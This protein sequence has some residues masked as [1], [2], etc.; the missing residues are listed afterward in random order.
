MTKRNLIIIIVLLAIIDIVAACWYVSQRIEQSGKSQDLF[1]KRDSTQVVVADTVTVTSV[2]DQFYGV[3]E[4]NAYFVSTSPADRSNQMSYYTS[5]KR[6]ATKWPRSVNGQDS[7]PALEKQLIKQAFGNGEP[8]V[9]KAREAY[10]ASPTFNKPVGSQYRRASEAP[11]TY[12]TYGNVTQVLVYPLITSDR[13]LVMEV[14]KV[15]YSGYGTM[16]ASSF[17]HYDR[18]RQHVLQRL[19]ILNADRSG[20]LLSLINDRIDEL[21]ARRGT[22]K[23]LSRALNVPV[24]FCCTRD[25]I[26]F[27]F[28]SGTIARDEAM[29]VSVPYDKLQPYLT[30]NFKQLIADND[31]YSQ[32]S[33]LEPKSISARSSK[34][35]AVTPTPP[36]VQNINPGTQVAPATGKQQGVKKQQPTQYRKRGYRRGYRRGYNRSGYNGQYRRG[37]RSSGTQSGQKSGQQQSGQQTTQQSGGQ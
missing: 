23:Q 15:D 30:D 28:Q 31:D 29:D 3:R 5:I 32:Y 6:V 21:N 12:T 33:K 8:T 17:V 36:R 27:A 10:L 13:L 4:M 18:R 34:P 24:D 2:A 14:D 26:T 16:R 7:L 9:Q 22:D 25:G 37:Y 1:N 35:K 20:Q 19:D 11:T